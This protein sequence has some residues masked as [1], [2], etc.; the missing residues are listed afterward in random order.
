M[1]TEPFMIKVP[2]STANLG[3]GFDSVGLAVDRYLELEVTAADEWEIEILSKELHGIPTDKQNLIFQV[4][5]HVAK[6]YGKEISPYFVKMKSSIPLARGLGSSAAAIVAG[7]EIANQALGDALSIDE[8]VRFASLWEGHPENVAASVYGGL[9]IGTHTTEETNVIYGGIPKVDL[10]SL[11]P[12][13]EL[14]TT[15]SRGV[16]PETLSYEQAIRGSSVANVLIA[17]MLQGD[18]ETAGKMMGEDV[19]HQPY[20]S[21]LIPHLQDVMHVT[22]NE[23]N[24]Y[25][26]ALSGAG[27]T[28]LCIAPKNEGVTI[29]EK[30]QME[31]PSFE[32]NVLQVASDGVTVRNGK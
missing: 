14:M 15:E 6:E 32:V 3:P 16:L 17:A 22:K 18:W 25:G 9:T 10:I 5:T 29:K 23:T 1:S 11:V 13:E 30:L 21:K 2:G 7:I 28:I 20:R 31:F 26:T 24:A 27:P 4:A 19:F 8:K 12:S